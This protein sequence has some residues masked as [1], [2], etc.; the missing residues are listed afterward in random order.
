MEEPPKGKK[1]YMDIFLK[2]D[3]AYHRYEMPD[4]AKYSLVHDFDRS[5]NLAKSESLS[6]YDPYDFLF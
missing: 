3:F 6:S 1:T 4:K 5:S 2:S